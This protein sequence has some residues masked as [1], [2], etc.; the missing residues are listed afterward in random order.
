MEITIRASWVKTEFGYCEG[1][2]LVY[3]KDN[4]VLMDDIDMYYTI[5]KLC[6]RINRLFI[7]NSRFIVHSAVYKKSEEA[8]YIECTDAKS[9]SRE[10]QVD[11]PAMS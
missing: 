1:W 8:L 3:D 4:K 6:M 10:M 5:E 11:E 7:N 9:G 2:I